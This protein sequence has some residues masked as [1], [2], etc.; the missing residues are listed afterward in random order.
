MVSTKDETDLYTHI[1]R[2]MKDG[3]ETEKNTI[4]S[5]EGEEVEK[6]KEILLVK[7]N[8]L[9]IDFFGEALMYEMV[10]NENTESYIKIRDMK[11]SEIIRL[12][13]RLLSWSTSEK[14]EDCLINTSYSFCT[15]Q[16]NVTANLEALMQVISLVDIKEYPELFRQS[17]SARE[18]KDLYKT[19]QGIK[20][21]H[22]LLDLSEC[23]EEKEKRK[24]EFLRIITY[25]F[26]EFQVETISSVYKLVIKSKNPFF[27][28]KYISEYIRIGKLTDK[29]KKIALCKFIIFFLVFPTK[30]EMLEIVCSFLYT[31]I[32]KEA[33]PL[34]FKNIAVVFAPIFFIDS[35]SAII[36]SNFKE[37][38]ERLSEFLEFLLENSLEI[39]LV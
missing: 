12:I 26:K 4:N 29:S 25:N 28:P 23:P 31:L 10:R 37:I 33:S 32:T 7:Y 20:F 30:R 38:M 2:N 5:L 13:L 24:E 1:Q 9:Y 36:D 27:P 19:L 21:P 11:I 22:S 18:I 34:K 15:K 17:A 16:L 6:Q 3:L 14:S 39:F 8:T 35:N